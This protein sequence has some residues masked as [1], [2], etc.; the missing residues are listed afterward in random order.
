MSSWANSKYVPGQFTGSTGAN[1]LSARE[2]T[3][4]YQAWAKKVRVGCRFNG[5]LH[6]VHLKER[7]TFYDRS[8]SPL[9]DALTQYN[10][11]TFIDSHGALIRGDSSLH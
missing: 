8:E 7:L 4:G 2:L 9:I 6:K 3:S 11:I 1:I 5:V 10:L